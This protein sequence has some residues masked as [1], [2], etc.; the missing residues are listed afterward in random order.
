MPR[1]GIRPRSVDGSVEHLLK[2]KWKSGATRTIRVPVTLADQLLELAHKLDQGEEIDLTQDNRS[3][4][5]RMAALALLRQAVTSKAKGGSY[6]GNNAT[7]I[8]RL[9]EQALA[10]LS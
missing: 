10:L 4:E 6:A 3:E 9:V 5:E 1:G 7:A 2:P 8:K